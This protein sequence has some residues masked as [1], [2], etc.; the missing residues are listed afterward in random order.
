MKCL[1]VDTQKSSHRWTQIIFAGSKV[2]SYQVLPEYICYNPIENQL[3]W[4][5]RSHLQRRK[6]SVV[7]VDK[8]ADLAGVC[9]GHKT[10]AVSLAISKWPG[11]RAGNTTSLSSTCYGL[12]YIPPKFLHC[13]PNLQC[14][15][16]WLFNE[17]VF[18]KVIKVKFDP[19]EPNPTWPVSFP[20]LAR[21]QTS[22]EERPC[23]DWGRKQGTCW[24]LISIFQPPRL[25]NK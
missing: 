20:E 18:K 23:E 12:N 3:A 1:W 25:W 16:I 13:G 5:R 6:M 4:Q 14:L 24:H 15:K 10:L 9:S 22:K 2:L 8:P 7:P 11:D 17:W 19:V 21:T